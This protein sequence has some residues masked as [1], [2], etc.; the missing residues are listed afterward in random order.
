MPCRTDDYGPPIDQ[1]KAKQTKDL[2]DDLC[3]A[4][5]VLERLGYDF[6]ENPSLSQWWDKHKKEDAAKRAKEEQAVQKE[7]WEKQQLALIMKKP[8]NSLTKEELA[9]LKR[10]NVL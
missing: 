9:L 5:R 2:T 8:L 7:V 6:D 10:K 1:A 3:S 4:C